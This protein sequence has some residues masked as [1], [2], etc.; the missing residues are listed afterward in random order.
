MLTFLKADFLR[1]ALKRV[2]SSNDTKT[3]VLG[4]AASALLLANIDWAKL[5]H[6]DSAEEGKAVG[7]VIV[8]AI[9]Y[10]TNKPAKQ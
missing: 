3:T 1:E 10:Y 6:G 4:A 2:A 8:A 5:L 9:G 7:A